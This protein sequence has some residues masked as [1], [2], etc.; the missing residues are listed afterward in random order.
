MTETTDH[1]YL[2]PNGHIHSS[3]MCSTLYAN[4]PVQ[5]LPALAGKTEAE[6]VAAHG[7]LLCTVCFHS[8]PVEHT[9]GTKP[10][11]DGMCDGIFPVKETDRGRAGICK[12]GYVG[13]V[14]THGK[15]RRH[16]LPA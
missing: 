8:A 11:R 3:N 1:Y 14:S 6:A 16:K 4:T 10:V 12:C 7:A 2:V 5:Y 9:N 13:N 15:L